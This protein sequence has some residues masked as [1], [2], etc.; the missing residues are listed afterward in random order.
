MQKTEHLCQ[1]GCLMVGFEQRLLLKIAA[2]QPT[3]SPR[4]SNRFGLYL[5]FLKTTQKLPKK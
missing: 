1:L 2:R 5:V 3:F 4:P